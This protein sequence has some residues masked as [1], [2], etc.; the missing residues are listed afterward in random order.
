VV[1]R[2]ELAQPFESSRDAHAHAET[3]G[4]VTLDGAALLA[5]VPPGGTPGRTITDPAD[6]AAAAVLAVLQAA[7]VR[8]LV[9][10]PID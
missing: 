6:P 5:A 2:Q 8:L 10:G 4:M 9:I 1:L 7:A 3:H